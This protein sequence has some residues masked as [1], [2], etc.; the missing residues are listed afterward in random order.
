[1]SGLPVVY[2]IIIVEGKYDKNTV[3]QVVD[4]I[5]IDVGG[6]GIF[7]D[8]AKRGAIRALAE[9]FGAVILTDSDGAGQLIR[10]RIK[11]AL[12]G[13]RVLDAY[14]P[15]IRG[16][17]KRKGGAEST[18]GVESMTRDTILK[19]L[20]DSGATFDNRENPGLRG[21]ISASDLY[22]MGLSGGS[23]SKVLRQKL[24]KHL[25]LP[26]SLNTNSLLRIINRQYRLEE[27]K[28]I[29]GGLKDAESV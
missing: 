6:F 24:L 13:C 1:M 12:A 3:S 21:N 17:V 15:E 7:N 9:K 4:A 29:I 8:S 23:N 25:G 28:S 27:V 5:V 19:A 10:T 20:L 2:E 26:A 18:L 11:N 22:E 16:R 14:I